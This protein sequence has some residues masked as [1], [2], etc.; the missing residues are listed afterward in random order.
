MDNNNSD[1]DSLDFGNDDGFV[2]ALEEGPKESKEKRPLLIS[3]TRFFVNVTQ[4]K[5]CMWSPILSPK[6]CSTS[7]RNI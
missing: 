5:I 1:E 6:K 7:R 3:V 4:G 2:K